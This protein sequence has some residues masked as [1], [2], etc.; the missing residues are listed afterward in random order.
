MRLESAEAFLLCMLVPV[1]GAQVMRQML[2]LAPNVVFNKLANVSQ[3]HTSD[4]RK[5]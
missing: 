3:E 1:L 2:G 5:R 4:F